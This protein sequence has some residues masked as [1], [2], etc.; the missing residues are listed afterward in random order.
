MQN[1]DFKKK[2]KLDLLLRNFRIQIAITNHHGRAYGTYLH[3]LVQ[4]LPTNKFLI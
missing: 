2:K 3:I 1:T 4:L